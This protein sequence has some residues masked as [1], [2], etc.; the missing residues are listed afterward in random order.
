MFKII[1]FLLWLSIIHALW[2]I[3]I[4][5]HN[6]W[7]KRLPCWRLNV[8]FR[9]LLGGKPLTG[10]HVYMMILF[11]TLFHGAF[12]FIQWNWEAE[13]KMIALLCWY[14]VIEDFLW[15]LLNKHYRWKNFWQQNIEWHKRWFFHLPISYWIAIILGIILFIIKIKEV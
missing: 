13:R 5:G 14:F 12:L 8:F 1:I 6:G 4:E 10:Y 15:F 2:E 11:I 3:Q 7:A 9:K